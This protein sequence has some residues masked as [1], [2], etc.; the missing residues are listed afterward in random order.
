MPVPSTNETLTSIQTEF[1]GSNPASM[2]EYYRGGANVPIGQAT[3]GVDGTPISTSGPIRM[4]MFRG[5]TKTPVNFTF[6]QTIS[7]N[8]ANYNLRNAAI[9]AGWN[10]STP[11]VA[12]VTVNGGVYVYSTSTGAW[13]FDTGSIPAGSSISLTNNGIIEGAG[14][15]GGGGAVVPNGV[16]NSFGGA[17]VG[18]AGGPALRAQFSM[19]IANNGTVAGGGGGGGGGGAVKTD[20][21]GKGTDVYGAPGSGGGGG[22]GANNGSPFGGAGGSGSTAAGCNTNLTGGNGA[23]G[24]TTAGGAGGSRAVVGGVIGAGVGGTGGTRGQPGA[25]GGN[26]DTS[27]GS[28][29]NL[30]YTFGAAGGAAGNCTNTTSGSI[31]WS[32][33]GTRLGTIA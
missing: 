15:T 8:T 23:S 22:A 10:G 12:N 4:G 1:G 11:L 14:G 13:A 2:S 31:T 16:L 5:L 30:G 17:G 9:A 6:N 26:P 3:S 24:S 32:V 19:T 18:G 7:S 27:V 20:Y 33:T 21:S 29:Y 25:A 28:Y